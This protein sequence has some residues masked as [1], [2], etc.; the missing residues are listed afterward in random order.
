[1]NEHEVERLQRE[2]DRLRC[3]CG[4][5]EN[6]MSQCPGEDDP[7]TGLGAV[8]RKLRAALGPAGRYEGEYVIEPPRAEL[9]PAGQRTYRVVY[10]I[11]LA[12]DSPRQAAEQVQEILRDPEALPPVFTVLDAEGHKTEVDLYA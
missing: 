3:L 1:M 12:A 8:L 9:G 7:L 6:W 4:V 11:D 10:E 5:V 2:N